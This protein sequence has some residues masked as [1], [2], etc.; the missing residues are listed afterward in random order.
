MT[1]T[2]E[3]GSA[4]VELDELLVVDVVLE[5]VVVDDVLV[6]AVV[7]AADVEGGAEGAGPPQAA[8]VKMTM[9]PMAAEDRLIL[10]PTPRNG[11]VTKSGM[12]IGTVPV[13]R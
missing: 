9:A 11:N 5:A 8:I 6:E 13:E 4:V 1:G 2:E 7:V 12:R 10:A 3:E